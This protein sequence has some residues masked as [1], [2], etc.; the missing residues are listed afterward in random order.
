MG[1]VPVVTEDASADFVTGALRSTGV[2]DA[3]TVVAE[4]EHD[5]IGEGVGLMCNLAR[6]TLRYGGPAHGAP[7]SVILKIPSNLP[8]NRGV[9]DHFSFYEREGQ[10]Y[11]NLSERLPVRTPHCYYN[12]IDSEANE[13]ALMIEDFGG[14]T[15]VSQIAGIEFERAAEAVRALALVHAEFW[16]SPKLESLAWLPT[17]IDPINLAAGAEYRKAW[18]HFMELFAGDL[19]DGS[20][21]LGELVGPNFESSSSATSNRSRGRWRTVISVPTT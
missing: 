19:P 10:F 2:I 1:N 14:R 17:V 13:F 9:G 11:A 12:H 7:S 8:E 21:A 3:D 18:D 5:R 4:V 15:M 6:L 16:N 20:V